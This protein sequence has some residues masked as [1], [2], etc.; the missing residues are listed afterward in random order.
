MFEEKRQ[1]LEQARVNLKRQFIGIDEIIDT[2][3]DKLTA[4]YLMPD[5]IT[6]PLTINLWGMTGVAK[7]DLVRKLVQEI[8]FADRFLEMQMGGKSSQNSWAPSTIQHRLSESDINQGE[9]GV[10]LFDEFQRFRT[11]D[12]DQREIR[13][14]EYQDLWML[15]S[16]GKFGLTADTKQTL[17]EMLLD[18]EF[19]K[20]RKDDEDECE[21]ELVTEET[22]E[23]EIKKK[24]AKQKV[25]NRRYY[26]AR[27]LKHS[28]NLTEDEKEIMKWTREHLMETV[29][30]IL[31]DGSAFRETDYSRMLIFI[32]GNL[33]E[34]FR[35]AVNVS[36]ADRDADEVRSRTEHVSVINIKDALQHR[37]KP[38]QISRLGNIHVI[39]PSISKQ[40]FVTMIERRLESHAEIASKH[41]NNVVMTF[42]ETIRE[43]IYENGVFPVQGV[44][45]LF[46]TIDDVFSAVVPAVAIAMAEYDDDI[47][48]IAVGYDRES[49]CI[50]ALLLSDKTQVVARHFIPF[51][52][53]L[54][55]IRERTLRDREHIMHVAVHEAGHA[56]AHTI[57]TGLSPIAL[58]I[59]LTSTS[60]AG[61]TTYVTGSDTFTTMEEDLVVGYAGIAAERM[62]FGRD[63]VGLGGTSDVET[64]TEM[65][66]Q[67]VRRSGVIDEFPSTIVPESC[68]SAPMMATD[69]ERTNAKI[70]E[71]MTKASDTADEVV[72]QNRGVLTAIAKEL[73]D[74][75]SVS[76]TRYTEICHEHGVTC[77]A[78]EVNDTNPLPYIEMF[79]KFVAEEVDGK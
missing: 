50:Q 62:V 45:P 41:L 54:D 39:Y 42:G 61:V 3:I 44:R 11:V 22:T 58:K 16:D 40:S 65:V 51:V 53:D 21:D 5:V 70:H 73:F 34:A 63:Q 12:E 27:W 74:T 26:R 57:Q 17:V 9:P 6:R 30:R 38:E 33:D 14:Y 55:E 32:A 47:D 46:S 25:Y 28:L 78:A 75:V 15:L 1:V 35:S 36:E 52:G 18:E 69:C 77:K 4:W 37:F 68:N 2:I 49:K 23:E 59:N 31:D 66:T 10:I 29:Q 48:T 72:Y 24:E 20:E 19:N 67:Y 64:M 7:T 8:G 13:D 60:A 56:I 71:L 43:F 76:P 79:D